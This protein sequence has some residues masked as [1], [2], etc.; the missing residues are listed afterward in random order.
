[1]AYQYKSDHLEEGLGRLTDVFRNAPNIRKLLS[2]YLKQVQLFED[3]LFAVA[4]ITL[5]TAV[6]DQ[7]DQYGALLKTPR[8]N[9]DDE[10]YLTAL[11]VEILL[12]SSSGTIEEIIEILNV[13]TGG[14]NTDLQEFYP[15]SFI[16]DIL[17]DWTPNL[18]VSN[19]VETLRRAKP[20]GVQGI[21]TFSEADAFQY[22]GT[23]PTGYDEG[24]YGGAIAI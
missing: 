14:L 23:G 20:L 6:G 18:N 8:D 13:L 7:L 21:V 3:A 11:R 12:R 4:S 5:G 16:M 22:D 2:S 9:R 1:M 10:D 17:T 19:I 24:P 15:A